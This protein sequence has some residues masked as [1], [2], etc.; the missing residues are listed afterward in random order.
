MVTLACVSRTVIA[1]AYSTPTTTDFKRM[2]L[3]D[4]TDQYWLPPTR[5]SHL[6]PFV[7]A[8][9]LTIIN[10]SPPRLHRRFRLRHHPS[11]ERT[12]RIPI[13][14]ASEDK[15][16]RPVLHRRPKF[17]PLPRICANTLYFPG[18]GTPGRSNSGDGPY[19]EASHTVV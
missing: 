12:H 4:Q 2:S 19:E 11:A 18:Q 3:S 1:Q 10:A 5:P 17:C 8:G 13:H 16:T 7:E 14:T 15:I 9:P 6:N